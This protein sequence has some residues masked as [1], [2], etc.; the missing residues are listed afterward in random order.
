MRNKSNRELW[1]KLSSW[2]KW[3]FKPQSEMSSSRVQS[4]S[5][6]TEVLPEHQHQGKIHSF[7]A[8]CE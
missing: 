1:A 4:D 3:R 6:N 2:V 5:R 8:H 7:E